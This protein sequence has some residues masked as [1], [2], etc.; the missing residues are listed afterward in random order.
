MRFAAVLAMSLCALA[1]P[2]L[3]QEGGTELISPILTTPDADDPWTAAEPE[4]ARV[5]H[6]ALDLD[7]DFTNRRVSGTATLDVMVAPTI[8]VGS[9]QSAG[10][11]RSSAS[12]SVVVWVMNSQ[13]SKSFS[14]AMFL[15]SA[16]ARAA[17]RSVRSPSSSPALTSSRLL[18]FDLP[19][20]VSGKDSIATKAA[21]IM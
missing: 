8:A 9:D 5:T 11:W 7:L 2:A 18:R 3:G 16:A 21:G 12:G 1:A 20:V 15:A 4:R 10:F 17:E 6:T 19:L 14:R 13:A